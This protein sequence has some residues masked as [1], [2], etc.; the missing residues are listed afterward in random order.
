MRWPRWV[1]ALHRAE[2]PGDPVERRHGRRRP[3]VPSFATPRRRGAGPSRG[4]RLLKGD[5]RCRCRSPG[6]H[7][8]AV[9]RGRCPQGPERWMP[10]RKV[11][12]RASTGT[13]RTSSTRCRGPGP[14]PRPKLGPAT[15]SPAAWT[16][17]VTLVRTR[18]RNARW[19][20]A[21]ERIRCRAAAW[22]AAVETTTGR[23]QHRAPARAERWRFIGVFC[24]RT[25]RMLGLGTRSRTSLPSMN[26]APVPE[27]GRV[28]R[29]SRSSF[30]SSGTPPRKISRMP[31]SPARSTFSI[32][33]TA[34]R[35]PTSATRPRYSCR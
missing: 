6:S 30:T 12:P 17:A 23:T 15:L 8:A 29:A 26:A 33:T 13:M 2:L 22:T 27:R 35:T 18:C 32:A 31:R 19:G 14:I 7:R 4:A 21:R 34:E 3:S 28:S 16:T 11:H 1:E 24:L 25:L 9:P 10:P 5:V 20:T